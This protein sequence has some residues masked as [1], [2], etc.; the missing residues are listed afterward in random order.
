MS[1][2][3]SALDTLFARF[4]AAL[5]ERGLTDEVIVVVTGDHGLRF[6]AE[7]DALGEPPVF[8]DATFHVPLIVFAPALFQTSTRIGSVTSHIDL[9][10]TLVDLIGLAADI[11]PWHGDHLLDGRIADR[12]TFLPSGVYPGLRPA[13]AV[14]WR[15]GTY[16]WHTAIDRVT[17]R[18]DG[19]AIEKPLGL[20]AE[21]ALS[22]DDVRRA[23]RTARELFR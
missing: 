4:L 18:R 2:V 10:P 7:F 20:A 14:H 12:M 23:I 1:H 9:A 19:D 6:R 5:D 16:T 3:L 15:E 13:D 11:R 22:A 17:W 21:E 8:G